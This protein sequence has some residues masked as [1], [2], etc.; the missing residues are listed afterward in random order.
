MF[1]VLEIS[2]YVLRIRDITYLFLAIGDPI[3]ER[4]RVDVII[5]VYLKN[6][7][8]LSWLFM[9]KLILQTSMRYKLYYMCKKHKWRSKNKNFPHQMQLLT[10]HMLILL[11]TRGGMQVVTNIIEVELVDSTTWEVEV[12]VEWTPPLVIGLPSSSAINMTIVSWI[13]GTYLIKHLYMYQARI[14]NKNNIQLEVDKP[15]YN[16]K[17]KK[18][19]LVK[20]Q[21]I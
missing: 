5:Q 12:V 6:I 1:F 2:K 16:N 14:K 10:L 19:M 13:A 7:T 21:H 3:V 9:E 18:I 11:T 20:P 15:M 4:D 8:H 17:V